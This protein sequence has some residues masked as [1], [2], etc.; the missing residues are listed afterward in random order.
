[1]CASEEARVPQRLPR[2]L[3]GY[4]LVQG[5]R[6]DDLPNPGFQ[7]DNLDSTRYSISIF[8]FLCTIVKIVPKI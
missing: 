3:Q 5:L 4:L 2:R 6:I 1:M 7:F 8:T